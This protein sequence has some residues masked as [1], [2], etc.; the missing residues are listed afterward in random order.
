MAS[1]VFLCSCFF[2]SYCALPDNLLKV[3]YV[4]A[5]GIYY[6]VVFFK[7]GIENRGLKLVSTTKFLVL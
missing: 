7:C 6:F 2:S 5:H 3:V 4:E 1:A